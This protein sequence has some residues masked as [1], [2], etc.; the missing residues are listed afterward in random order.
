MKQN[1]EIVIMIMSTV[2]YMVVR[3]KTRRCRV[4]I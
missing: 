3:F 2:S 1:V 4:M